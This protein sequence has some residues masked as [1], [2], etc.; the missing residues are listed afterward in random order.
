MTKKE[1][2]DNIKKTIDSIGSCSSIKDTNIDFYNYLTKEILPKRPD[3]WLPI[4]DIIVDLKIQLNGW[5][6]AYELICLLKD[7][8][9]KDISWRKCFMTKTVIQK[10]DHDRAFRHA[11]LPEIFEFRINNTQVCNYCKADKDIQVDHIVPMKELISK[12]YNKTGI[13]KVTSFAKDPKTNQ[14]MFKLQ[15]SA[16]KSKWIKFHNSAA[17]LRILC[18][19]C[20]RK[21][22]GKNFS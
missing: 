12:F 17:K 15:D 10:H 11:I 16:I 9:E 18:G 7:G 13:K 6:T 5:G 4:K 14:S 1:I 3:K 8:Q 19:T 2:K 21:R 20:N 22:N